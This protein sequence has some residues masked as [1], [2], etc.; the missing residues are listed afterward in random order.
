MKKRRYFLPLALVAFA[1]A[2]TGGVILAQ[3]SPS[4]ESVNSPIGT[5]P[6]GLSRQINSFNRGDSGRIELSHGDAPKQSMASRV[7]EI[8][9][10]EE[11][12]LQNAFDQARREKQDDSLAYRLEHLVADEKL[13]QA[14]ADKILVWFRSRPDAAAKLHRLLL[15]GGEA[16]KHRLYH[17]VE[18]GVISQDEANAV[19]EWHDATPQPFKDLSKHRFHRSSDSQAGARFRPSER[20]QGWDMNRL[21]FEGRRFGREGFS[22]RFF[23]RGR[24][25]GG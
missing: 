3:K 1:V 2:V 16:V 7:A 15:R 20:F 22:D 10:M 12:V 24:M 4:Q 21:G 23:R 8:L 6:E 14:E 9:D 11:E 5:S 18:C 25:R 19:Q 17:M 13:T